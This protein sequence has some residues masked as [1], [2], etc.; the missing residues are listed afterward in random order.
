MKCRQCKKGG[1][2]ESLAEGEVELHCHNCGG[3]IHFQNWCNL[4]PKN[5]E[6]LMEQ[7]EEERMGRL[8]QAADFFMDQETKKAQGQ[9]NVL[10]T[11]RLQLR[12]QLYRTEKYYQ[13]KEKQEKRLKRV[14]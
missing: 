9:P 14:K 4:T 2:V 1:Y 5:V 13:V 11:V 7:S 6:Y 8:W 3:T 12:E 10:D